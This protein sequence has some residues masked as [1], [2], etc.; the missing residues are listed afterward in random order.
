MP[1]VERVSEQEY[2]RI[3]L[4]DDDHLWELH[5]GRLREKPGMGVEHNDLLTE[6]AFALRSQLGRREFRVRSNSARTRHTAESYYIPDVVV[7]PVELERPLRGRPGTLEIYNEP[8]P[9]VVEVWSRSTGG[10]DVNTKLPEYRA[11]GDLEIW[12]I[13]PFERTLTVWRRQPD[14]SY[15]ESVCRGG[16]V[17]PA[18]LPGVVIDLDALFEA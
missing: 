13:Q 15:A 14:G 1:V 10:Y 12:R 4:G 7:V 9:L 8:L 11:R 6:L 17:R 16:V 2:R 3:A 5:Q 18:S